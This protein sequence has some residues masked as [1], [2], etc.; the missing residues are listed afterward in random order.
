MTDQ[1]VEQLY[2]AA[3]EAGIKLQQARD[4][5]EKANLEFKEART[6]KRA[7][8]VELERAVKADFAALT[9]WREARLNASIH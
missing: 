3:C 9:A 6:E 7:A 4:W 2:V 5:L 8:E 1:T